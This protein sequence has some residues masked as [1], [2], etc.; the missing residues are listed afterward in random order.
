MIKHIILLI[1]IIVI[2]E[3]Y[4]Y[5]SKRKRWLVTVQL[6]R[7]KKPTQTI[8]WQIL[9]IDINKQIYFQD[10]YICIFLLNKEWYAESMKA[11]NSPQIILH[12][13][14][15]KF[16]LLTSNSERI[17]NISVLVLIAFICTPIRAFGHHHKAAFITCVDNRTYKN[18]AEFMTMWMDLESIA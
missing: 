1:W 4:F 5:W 6:S 9:K 14:F 2:N 7:K 18:W 8:Q 15:Y 11:R 12:K 10:W 17:K 16:D 3:L 13:K